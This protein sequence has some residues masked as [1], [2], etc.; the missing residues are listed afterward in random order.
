MQTVPTTICDRCGRQG[1]YLRIDGTNGM[2]AWG[3]DL[4]KWCY[5]DVR[6]MM[7]NATNRYRKIE[8]SGS[9]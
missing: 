6:A 4:C 9:D 5:E 8:D 2:I 3:A 7:L 1:T